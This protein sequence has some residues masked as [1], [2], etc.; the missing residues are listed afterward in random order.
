MK[1]RE[2]AKKIQMMSEKDLHKELA[3][4]REELRDLR[5]KTSQNQ[6]KQVHSVKVVRKAI[7]RILT[8]LNAKKETKA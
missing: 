5:F 3:A 6:L 2:E 4:K 1:S 7:S 8:A